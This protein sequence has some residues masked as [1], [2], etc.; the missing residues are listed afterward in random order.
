MKRNFL[1]KIGLVFFV[2]VTV[3]FMSCQNPFLADATNLYKVDFE[4][5][6]GTLID[7]YRTCKIDFMPETTKSGYVFDGWYTDSSCEGKIITFPYE[8]KSDTTLYAKWIEKESILT[9]NFEDCETNN[10]FI[11]KCKEYGYENGVLEL[12]SDDELFVFNGSDVQSAVFNNLCIIVAKP[13]RKLVFENFSFSSS[14][15]SPLIKSSFD[16]MIEYKG[17]NKIS[18]LSSDKI[19]LIESLGLITFK[20]TDNNSSFEIQPNAVTSSKEGSIGVDANKV[21]IDGGNFVILGSN[22]VNYSESDKSGKSGRNGSSGIKAT[23]TIIQ[24]KANVT[25]TG[26]NGGKGTQGTQG[27][28]GAEGRAKDW[29]WES[30][31]T[32]GGTGC[33]GGTGGAGGNGGTAI[34]GNLVVKSSCNLVL[35][36]GNGAKGGKGGKGGTGGKGGW[37]SIVSVWSAKGGTGGTGGKGGSGGNGGDA[38]SGTFIC[39][40]SIAILTGGNFGE[41]GDPG[42]RGNGGAGGDQIGWGAGP[43]EVGDFGKPGNSGN[44]GKDGVEHR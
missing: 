13:N 29:V 14:K 28:T 42:D 4:T 35:T 32:Q 23:E 25:I 2:V 20:G 36:G 18:S 34:F 1:E 26:G 19:S 11:N 33:S 37:T 44:S 8:L 22:G 10:D 12:N 27:K 41:G 5:N 3:F 43:G 7:P 38:I 30:G 15:S 9:L 16:I 6:G 24:N 21:I 40:D 31:P 17:V 39:E